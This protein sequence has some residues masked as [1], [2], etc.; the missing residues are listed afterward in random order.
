MIRPWEQWGCIT[1]EECS[2]L[3]LET[4]SP[5]N[6][7]PSP[8]K[9]F[10]SVGHH[11][12]RRESALELEKANVS[13]LIGP[14]SIGVATCSDENQIFRQKEAVALV[15]NIEAPLLA[16][17]CECDGGG[18]VFVCL[19]FWYSCAVS[20]WVYAV[21]LHIWLSTLIN[22][23]LCIFWRFPQISAVTRG[24]GCHLLQPYTES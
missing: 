1:A 6:I 18:V 3:S 12:W 23:V 17:V 5:L 10:H 20:V 21:L 9:P 2:L 7:L 4:G 19:W 22:R 15:S 24:L 13:L 16:S 14:V 11:T 8:L